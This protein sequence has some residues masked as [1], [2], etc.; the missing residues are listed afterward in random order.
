MRYI[1]FIPERLSGKR[2]YCFTSILERACKPTI[3]QQ[4]CLCS[5]P[6]QIYGVPVSRPPHTPHP[7]PVPMELGCC[8]TQANW[9]GVRNIK[10][11]T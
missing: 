2:W 5:L 8:Q 11:I 3:K 4:Y 10:Y 1:N 7:S 6:G 9:T